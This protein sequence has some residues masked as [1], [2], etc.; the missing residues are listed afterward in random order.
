MG[1]NVLCVAQIWW[2]YWFSVVMVVL[3]HIVFRFRSLPGASGRGD[4]CS[5]K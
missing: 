4:C 3:E 1:V 5:S 2:R